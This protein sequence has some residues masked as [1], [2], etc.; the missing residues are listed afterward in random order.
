MVPWLSYVFRGF[1]LEKCD[2][3]VLRKQISRK[4]IQ[5][6]RALDC[7]IYVYNHRLHGDINL[8]IIFACV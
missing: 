7:I 5:G 4:K 3:F 8:L 6:T 2:N 1:N